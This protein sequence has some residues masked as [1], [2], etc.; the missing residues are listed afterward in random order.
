MKAENSSVTNKV[1]DS[2]PD[3]GDA[4]IIGHRWLPE[5]KG[6]TGEEHYFVARIRGDHLCGVRIYSGDWVMFKAAHKA[7]RGQLIVVRT[8][9]G[10][11]ARFYHPKRNGRVVLKAVDGVTRDQVYDFDELDII[12]IVTA[13]GRDWETPKKAV[14]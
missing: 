10:L 14:S 3:L 5:P 11:T 6:S 12:G 9:T 7:K 2:K 8:S 13:S 4:V 1:A